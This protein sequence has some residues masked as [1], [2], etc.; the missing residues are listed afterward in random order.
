M[1]LKRREKRGF[2]LTE[3]IVVIIIIGILATLALT[4]YRPV[5]ER[6][7][8]KEA[9]A[10]LRLI[11]AAQRIYRMEAGFFYPRTGTETTADMNRDLKLALPT[12]NWSYGTTS[13]ISTASR[14]SGTR[15]WTLSVG[16]TLGC[17]GGSVNDPCPPT[18]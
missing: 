1:K 5:R 10:N 7:L 16:G 12:Q 18:P 3:L 4:H 17:T 15:V 13:G 6:S 2:T 14:A 9:Q 11:E 8:D